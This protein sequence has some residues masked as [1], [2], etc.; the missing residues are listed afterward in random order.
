MQLKQLA[1]KDVCCLVRYQK[2]GTDA[3][4]QH[5][6]TGTVRIRTQYYCHIRIIHLQE[7]PQQLSGFHGIGTSR[8]VESHY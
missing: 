3:R 1:S 8:I 2:R 5:Y 4:E 7:T 6:I